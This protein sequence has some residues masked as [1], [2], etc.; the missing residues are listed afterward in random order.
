MLAADGTLVSIGNPGIVGTLRI[1]DATSTAAQRSLVIYGTKATSASGAQK[2][3]WG[4]AI[5]APEL[6]T[7][8]LNIGSDAMR[9]T[10]VFRCMPDPTST[11]TANQIRTD[12]SVT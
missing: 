8:F 9:R 11:P 12:S 3:T 10:I 6:E 5:R 2:Y 1:G 4:V 7:E